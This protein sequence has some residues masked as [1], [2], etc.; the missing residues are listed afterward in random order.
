MCPKIG[1]VSKAI[2][3]QIMQRMPIKIDH[4]FTPDTA[5]DNKTEQLNTD[6]EKSKLL[7]MWL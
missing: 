2:F 3:V 7:F 5:D 1:H 6:T 4:I